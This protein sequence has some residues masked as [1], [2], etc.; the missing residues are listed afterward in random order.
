MR[1]RYRITAAGVALSLFLAALAAFAVRPSAGQPAPGDLTPDRA[2]I[3]PEKRAAVA[4]EYLSPPTA[5]T[6][7]FSHLLIRREATVPPGAALTLFVR[8]STNGAD[9]TR[10]EEIVA[11]D[12]LYAPT[13]GPDV[14][15]SQIVD[16]GA[17]ARFWQVRALSAAAPNGALPELR[18]VEVNTVDASQGPAAV[19]PAFDKAAGKPP[20][21]SRTAWG[22]PDG[23]GS[24]ARPD[25]YPVSHLVV[26]H[27][28]DPNPL[29]PGEVNWPARVRAIWSYHAITRG[30]GDI[31]YN[32]LIDPFGTIYEGRAGGDDAVAFHDTANY[33][34]LGVAML[35]TF[36][37]T[38][39]SDATLDA[40]VRLL[41][42]KADQKDIDPLGRSYYYGCTISRYCRPYNPGAVVPNIAGHR[43]VTPGHTSCPGDATMARLPEIRNRVKQ[44]I[45]S[46][47]AGGGRP[48]DGD[49]Q[50]DELEGSFARSPANWYDAACGA[51]GHAYYTFGTDDPAQ[52][53]NSATWRPNI[54]ARARYRVYAYVP[55]SCGPGQASANAVYR[56][57]SADGDTQWAVNQGAADGWVDLGA[58]TFDAGTSGAVELYDLTG[59]PL[60]ARRVLLFDA[61]KWVK[62]DPAASVALVDVA[63]DRTTLASGELLKVTFTVENTGPSMLYGQAPRVDLGAGGGQGALENG[64]VYEQGECFAGDPSGA[65]PAFLKETDRIR[66]TLGMPGW[67]GA[68]AGRCSAPTS[69]Y[70]WRWGLNEPLAPGQRQTIV[71]YVRMRQPGVYTVQAGAIQEYVRYH[72]QGVAAT[73]ITVTPERTPP[74]AAA[75]DEQLRPLAHVYYLGETSDSALAR[76]TSLPDVPLGAYVGSIPWGG[77]FTDWGDGG[78]LG[79]AD[80]FVVVQVRAFLAPSAGEYTFR[81]LSDDGSWLLVDGRPV[82]ANGGLHALSEATGAATLA[83]GVHALTFVAFERT[84]QAA[85]GYEVRSPGGLAFTPVLDGL[86]GGALHVGG[87]FAEHPDLT[88]AADDGGSGVALV[89]WRWAGGAWQ[90]SSGGLLR[91]GRLQNGTYRL[92]YQ[93]VDAAGN[94]G[95][96]R[97]LAFKVDTSVALHRQYIPL[98]ER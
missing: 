49:L 51:G 24:R 94:A 80:R 13:D 57:R 3:V 58:Y 2:V 22:S 15:W 41:A 48:D 47:G 63:Y 67:D 97:E 74:D 70:P 52:S 27:T 76:A 59:E 4:P 12:D 50:V 53:T 33:G 31:G 82:V 64:H 56:I 28:A 77:T 11:N 5:A 60:S 35:G 39:P 18:R 43:Q 65:S 83:A 71:G 54:P 88:L 78:P 89:R 91:V 98:A 1:A 79:V 14:L 40:L 38:A 42:W 26:H 81:T 37:S 85:A 20:V 69:D 34:S 55:A 8:V 36:Q 90:D 9:W 62:E 84:G 32:Y 95:P 87:V 19:A 96:E 17:L 30:W 75:Y 10:W 44:L 21:V 29:Y 61:V 6:R 68:N 93:A 66:V 25:Y 73:Q 72:A 86:G 16:V 23:Q 46:G 7:P 45:E 92:Q